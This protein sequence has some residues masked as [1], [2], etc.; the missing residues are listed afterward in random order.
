MVAFIVVPVVEIYVIIQVG[1]VIGAWWTILL[2]IADSIFGSWLVKKEGAKAWQALQLALE[3]RRLPHRELADGVLILVGGT[4]MITPGFVSDIF[5]I[6]CILPFTR[7]IGRRI[8]A[9]MLS[10][11][12]LGA[13]TGTWSGTPPPGTPRRPGTDDVVRGEVV[14]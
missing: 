1:Q 9:G 5:G 6:L 14:D 10:R 8:L 4:L 7:P 3:E 12:L 13:S 11:R 2:L